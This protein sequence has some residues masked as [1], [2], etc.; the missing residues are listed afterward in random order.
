MKGYYNKPEATAA[1]IDGE[2]WFATGDVGEIDADGFL[3][4]TDR[5]KDLIVTS[6]GKNVAP[7][8]IENRLKTNLFVEQAV[9]LGD[10]RP[11]LVLL[12]VPAI[13]ALEQWA[14]ENGIEWLNV[15]ELV[16]NELVLAHVESEVLGMLSGLASFETPKKIALLS[17]ELTIENGMLTP[18]L[19]VKRSSVE[20]G[21]AGV[22]E[23]LY[24][25][26]V[27]DEPES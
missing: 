24:A 11:Y 4:I 22:I 27:V 18:T 25:D 1:V 3:Y 26:T 9:I 2:G 19:K 10:R 17:E 12:V 21:F 7:Q 5:K 16:S 14:S 20:E 23:E 6:G 15:K 8:P 13:E